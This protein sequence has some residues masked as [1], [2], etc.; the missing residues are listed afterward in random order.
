MSRAELIALAIRDGIPAAVKFV[1][2]LR[3]PVDDVTPE[4]WKE[5]EAFAARSADD[6]KAKRQ[7]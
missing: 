2:V 4:M 7:G 5:L 1:Q 3:V 6:Y